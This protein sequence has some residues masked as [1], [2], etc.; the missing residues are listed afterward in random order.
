MTAAELDAIEARANAAS[1]G[2]WTYCGC[3]K[4]AQVSMEKG[5]IVMVGIGARDVSYTC[6][7]GVDDASRLLNAEFCAHARQDVPALVAEV[8]RLRELVQVGPRLSGPGSP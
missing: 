6:G 8:R 2:P 7:E 3:G 4:C 1:A 5:P